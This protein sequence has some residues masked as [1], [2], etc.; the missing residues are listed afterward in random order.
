MY[1]LIIIGTGPA[2][3]TASIYASCFRIKHIVIGEKLGGQMMLAPDILN[4]PGF[5]EISGKE[6]TERMVN[7]VKGLGTEVLTQNVIEIIKRAVNDENYFEVTTQ[8]GKNYQSKALILAT[9]T[10]RRKLNI[11]GEVEYTGKGVYYCAVCKRQ[12]YENQICA[13]IGGG[14]SALQAAVQLSQAASKVYIIYRGK[15]LRGEAVWL[16]RLKENKKVEMLFE[17]VVHE[18]TGDGKK[19]AGLDIKQLNG[20]TAKKLAIDKVFI[21]IGGVPGSSLIIPLGVN[22]NERGYVIVDGKLSTNVPGVFACGDLVSSDSS[23][24]QIAT[25]VGLG[26]RVAASVFAYLKEGSAPTLWG[27]SQIK[28]QV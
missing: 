25:A 9:G 20:D 22:I 14:N 19:V 3:L 17:T 23:I 27:K 2:G 11:K 24:E 5:S 8:N 1:D 21:E 13:V 4:Y 28:R 10:E 26:A 15:E 7:Q 18:I 6:L 16:D 12:D